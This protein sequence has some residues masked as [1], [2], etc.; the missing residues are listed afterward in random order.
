MQMVEE[1]TGDDGVL[2]QPFLSPAFSSITLTL[3]TGK[4]G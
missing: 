1:K 2:H 3:L 4:H